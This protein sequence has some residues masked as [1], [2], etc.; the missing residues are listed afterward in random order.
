MTRKI[1]IILGV[2]FFMNAFSS[3]VIFGYGTSGKRD[4]FVSLIGIEKRAATRL[5]D[6][7]SIDEIKVEGIAIGQNGKKSVI[8]NGELLKEGSRVGA[9]KIK[10]ITRGSVKLSIGSITYNKKIPEEGGIKREK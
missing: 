1:I 8:M 6:I 4:P 2:M 7:T 9:I 5:E 3:G 10:K